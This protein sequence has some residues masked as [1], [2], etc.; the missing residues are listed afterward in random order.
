MIFIADNVVEDLSNLRFLLNKL[1][2]N[3]CIWPQNERPYTDWDDVSRELSAN[4]KNNKDLLVFL[5]LGL[6][7]LH[8]SSATSGVERAS[9]LRTLR[10]SAVFLAYTQFGNRVKGEHHYRE[11]FDGLIDKQKLRSLDTINEQLNYLKQ[12]IFTAR[13]SKYG[14][15]TDYEFVDS[16]GLRLAA[17][18]FGNQVF[19]LLI[20]EVAHD[21]NEIKVTALT[22]GHSGA[23]L[24]EISGKHNGGARRLIV[25][26]SRDKETIEG[27]ITR[28]S[29]T[30]AELG[31]LAEV[32]GQ[33]NQ[34]LQHLPGEIGYYYQQAAIQGE[35]LESILT[36]S[37]WSDHAKQSLDGILELELKCYNR[38]STEPYAKLEPLKQF[39]LSP[40]DMGRARQS[41]KFLSEAGTCCENLRL[42]P[43]GIPS[44]VQVAEDIANAIGRWDDLM[45]E[46]GELLA[47]GQHG[48]LNLGN[49]LVPTPGKVVLID[50]SRLGTWPVGYDIG[51]LAIML[52]IRL[53]DHVHNQDW[54]ENRL[55]VWATDRFGQVDLEQNPDNSVCPSATYV[56]QR[57]RSFLDM[58][59]VE[60]RVI[61]V[62]GYQMGILWDLIKVLSYGDLSPFKRIWA[63]I[64]CWRLVQELRPRS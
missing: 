26:C 31:P 19:D 35:S 40:V 37:S 52:R 28:A 30:L 47:V 4:T 16:L 12:E 49:V 27:E 9:L 29:E 60:E 14:I 44:A 32:M 58:R 61:L 39:S 54:I 36:H 56:E 7:S 25:K 34:K 42:W 43:D 6:E 1:F 45:N 53:T 22:S 55:K 46:Q 20:H 5:D 10:D 59:P 63:M 13:S 24:L 41:L 11:T 62:R 23:F 33:I 21:W 17:A 57:F 15:R 48:D 18:A 51:R 50:F 2:P 38:S 8:M 64:E 3:E